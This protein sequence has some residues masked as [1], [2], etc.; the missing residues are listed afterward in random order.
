[1]GTNLLK[2]VTGMQQ[3]IENVS[4]TYGKNMLD[5]IVHIDKLEREHPVLKRHNE[6]IQDNLVSLIESLSSAE[7]ISRLERAG[8]RRGDYRAYPRAKQEIFRGMFINS[9]VYDRMIKTI[10]EYVEG[11]DK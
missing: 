9:D 10:I 11:G 7:I 5:G 8:I 6:R 3:K 1:M 4:S 2:L